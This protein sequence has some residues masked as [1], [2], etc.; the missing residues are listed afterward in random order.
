MDW[1]LVRKIDPIVRAPDRRIDHVLGIG[2]R[3]AGEDFFAHVGVTTS[4]RILEKPDFGSGC[5]H[6]ASIPTHHGIRHHQV[7]GKHRAAIGYAIA[8][9]V[10]EEDDAACRS[11]VERIAS[12]LGD[13][14]APIFV[15]VHGHR[16]LNHRLGGKELDVKSLVNVDGIQCF[17]RPVG[18]TRSPPGAGAHNNTHYDRHHCNQQKSAEKPNR[19]SS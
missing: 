3:E 9:C 10:L 18:G 14:D 2:E 17:L 6:H 7:I 12:I 8:V 1:A 4:H 13:I 19:F 15:P 16:T 11:R 5:H